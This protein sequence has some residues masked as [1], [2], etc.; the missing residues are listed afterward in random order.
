MITAVLKPLRSEDSLEALRDC[1]RAHD[2]NWVH[3]VATRCGLGEEHGMNLRRIEDAAYG[4][5]WL[6]LAHEWRCDLNASLVGQL[7]LRWLEPVQCSIWATSAAGADTG[8][9]RESATIPTG[10]YE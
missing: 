6:E 3:G 4:F 8:P 5:R 7:P 1:S 10:A 9:H 2:G